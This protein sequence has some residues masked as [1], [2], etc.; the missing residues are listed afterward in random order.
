METGH[1]SFLKGAELVTDV[2][3][4]GHSYTAA[5]GCNSRATWAVGMRKT[6]SV[7]SF[8]GNW[9]PRLLIYMVISLGFQSRYRFF[10]PRTIY[11]GLWPQGVPCDC[12]QGLC[13]HTLKMPQG[14]LWKSNSGCPPECEDWPLAHKVSGSPLTCNKFG[15]VVSKDAWGCC[16]QYWGCEVGWA[17]RY[18]D[19]LPAGHSTQLRSTGRAEVV[20]AST[21]QLHS[22][23]T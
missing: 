10:P 3:T 7:C 11:P 1:W 4:W 23:S 12:S 21:T 9:F 22:T 5:G 15:Q 19:S 6:C 13:D 2:K 14:R 18:L 17:G 16:W 20:K 8:S